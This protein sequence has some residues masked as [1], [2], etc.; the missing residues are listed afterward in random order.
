MS[1]AHDIENLNPHPKLCDTTTSI[2][3][4]PN[5][6]SVRG[7]IMVA[8]RK[9]NEGNLV[10]LLFQD[11]ENMA[12][13][14][15]IGIDW[16]K[17]VVT[18]EMDVKVRQIGEGAWR[19]IW[20]NL[21][22]KK[23]HEG[24]QLMNIILPEPDTQDLRPS[25]LVVEDLTERFGVG[26]TRGDVTGV[27]VQ[28]HN[29]QVNDHEFFPLVLDLAK[30]MGLRGENV[31]KSRPVSNGEAGSSKGAAESR[32]SQ[33]QSVGKNGP[34]QDPPQGPPQDPPRDP[35]QD[36]PQDPPEP[37]PILPLDIEETK[38]LVVVIFPEWGCVRQGSI[39]QVHPHDPI[40]SA[41]IAPILRFKFEVKGNHRKI[42]TTLNT[43]CN[44]GQG[45]PKITPKDPGYFQDNITISLNCKRER[46]ATLSSARVENVEV[47]KRTITHTDSRSS[48]RGCSGQLGGPGQLL[49]RFGVQ[50]EASYGGTTERSDSFAHEIS[51]TQ[52]GCFHV[53]PQELAGSLVYNFL[54]P[55]EVL[56]Y[57]A[58]GNHGPRELISVGI[59][60]T[61]WPSI[62]G[63]WDNLDT[64]K[65]SKY[66]FKTKRD[67]TSVVGLR[68]SHAN[69][70]EPQ[71]FQQSYEVPLWVNHAMTHIFHSHKIIELRGPGGRRINH[72]IGTNP[73][74][75]VDGT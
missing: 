57:I 74:L 22:M 2:E 33:E 11:A 46:A 28:D 41:T 51:T 19:D 31:T 32:S 70:E 58:D 73:A 71:S 18:K 56:D 4:G 61:F 3:G 62:V 14:V 47:V 48:A 43:Q 6:P 72:V 50:A 75:H 16:A 36:P 67:I 66:S 40:N 29:E 1:T 39:A 55:P 15:G 5:L 42:T 24:F 64:S 17:V 26:L 27:Y 44:L 65:K 54:Y 53:N 49:S 59:G 23:A 7:S 9:D 45:G 10:E 35:C 69:R 37:L 38:V 60:R 68:R 13:V 63:E 52:L 34:P 8:G 12:E 20:V 30:Y 21:D 25:Q